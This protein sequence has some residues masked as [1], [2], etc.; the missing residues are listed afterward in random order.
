MLFLGGSKAF[1]FIHKLDKELFD[2]KIVFSNS[3]N[4]IKIVELDKIKTTDVKMLFLPRS[5]HINHIR[6]LTTTFRLITLI[7][8]NFR[9][10]ILIVLKQVGYSVLQN[11]FVMSY[12]YFMHYTASIFKAKKEFINTFLWYGIGNFIADKIIVS[13][14]EQKEVNRY[15]I[16]NKKKIELL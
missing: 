15:H 2:I 12:Q 14:S 5:N 6:D 13:E 4:E 7:K 1:S 3:R 16:A 8:T 11:D 9:L 10:C